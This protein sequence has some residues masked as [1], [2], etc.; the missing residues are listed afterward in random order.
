MSVFTSSLCC[1]KF[2][3]GLI[4]W[5]NRFHVEKVGD[6]VELWGIQLGSYNNRSGL[7]RGTFLH[8]IFD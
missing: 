5:S 2:V 1:V 6:R 4:V 8:S 7:S 3:N